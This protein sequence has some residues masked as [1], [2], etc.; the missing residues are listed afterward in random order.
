MRMKTTLATQKWWYAT[1]AG[2]AFTRLPD[3][4]FEELVK[5]FLDTLPQEI[6]EY[7]K[8]DAEFGWLVRQIA[9]HPY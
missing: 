5:V 6:V 9:N 7:L 1:L 2:W 4:Q 8:Q 3:P